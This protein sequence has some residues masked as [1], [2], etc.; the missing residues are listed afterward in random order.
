MPLNFEEN[1][2]RD[3]EVMNLAKRIKIK[4]DHTLKGRPL[5]PST[6]RIELNRGETVTEKIDVMKGQPGNPL[7][8]EELLQKMKGFLSYA[9]FS[10]DE[11]KF[12]ELVTVVENLEQL[13][14]VSGLANLLHRDYTHRH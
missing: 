7:T 3:P 14:D 8:R 12:E 10:I 5:A 4:V 11:R 6:I 2:V 1:A 9:V 13:D